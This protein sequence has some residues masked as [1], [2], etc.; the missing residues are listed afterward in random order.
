MDKFVVKVWRHSSLYETYQGE[1]PRKVFIDRRQKSRPTC[2]LVEEHSQASGATGSDSVLANPV[3]MYKINDSGNCVWRSLSERDWKTLL[4][5]NWT[6]SSYDIPVV[7]TGFQKRRF[8]MQWLEEF[9]WLACSEMQFCKWCVAFAPDVV[10]R[11]AKAL[12]MLVK[13][14]HRNWK[15][16]KED[17][18]SHQTRNTTIFGQRSLMHFL[19]FA[20]M[21][22]TWTWEICCPTVEKNHRSKQNSSER[23]NQGCRVLRSSGRN[24][25]EARWRFSWKDSQFSWWVHS[26]LFIHKLCA[27]LGYSNHKQFFFLKLFCFH[28]FSPSVIKILAATTPL[29]LRWMRGSP[30]TECAWTTAPYICG[31][32]KQ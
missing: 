6:P 11:S 23:C 24:M 3:N 8:Q 28:N 32:N 30:P 7:H 5:N 29:A 9:K 22:R 1:Q 14:G 16:A 12:G 27:I 31:A 18:K 21:K 4:L 17:Y 20:K 13:S 15:K 26:Q 25:E 2:P 19:N 10:N